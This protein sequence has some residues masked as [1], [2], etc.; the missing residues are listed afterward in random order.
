MAQN[1]I[2]AYLYT[3]IK[4]DI[5]TGAEFHETSI[6]ALE[7]NFARQ[8]LTVATHQPTHVFIVLHNHDF[9]GLTSSSSS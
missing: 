7:E 2:T 8:K 5:F 3:N 4:Q 1:V 6:F 9:R